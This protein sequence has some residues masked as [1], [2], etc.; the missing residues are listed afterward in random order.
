MMTDPQRRGRRPLIISHAACK[1]HAPE[2]TLAGIRA[3]LALG[4]DAIEID[5]HATAGGV[6]VLLHDDTVDRTTDGTGDVRAMSLADVRRLDAGAKSFEGRFSGERI[7]TLEEVLE[8][9]RGRALLIAEIK[10]ANIEQLVA[11]LVRRMDM[12][13]EAMVWSFQPAVVARMRAIAP[14]IPCSQLWSERV[15]DMVKMCATALASNAQAVS[16]NHSFI[17]A[18]LV[19]RALL[20]GLRVFAW[21]AD[22]PADIQRL[23]ELDVD[24]ICS[25]YP[26]RVREALR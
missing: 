18:P 3:A 19:H 8:L 6:A 10:Q 2:N 21:T 13:D 26:E 15:P 22:E 17:D 12:A 11:D 14:E 23:I 4:C 5:V 24:G 25:N 16:P 20:H 7:P 1:G 9:T